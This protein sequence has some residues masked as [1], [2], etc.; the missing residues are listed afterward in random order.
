MNPQN[1]GGSVTFTATVTPGTERGSVAPTGSVYFY[2]GST[3]LGSTAVALSGGSYTAAYAT[4][5]L[6]AG[7]HTITALYG[8]DSNYAS[9]S[10]TATEA[11]MRG[12]DTM[13]SR[14]S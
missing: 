8:G 6:T 3:L 14:H 7:S 12:L 11:C 1:S 5:T 9:S 10:G 13:E 4:T 2:D